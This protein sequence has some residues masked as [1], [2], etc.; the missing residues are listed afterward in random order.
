M[1]SKYVR[2]VLYLILSG[3]LIACGGSGSDD[4]TSE[5]LEDREVSTGIITGFGSV[6]VNGTRYDTSSATIRSDGS[7]LND[8]TELKVGMVATVTSNS[9]NVAS[10]VDYEE[11]VKGPVDVLV[12][13]FGSPFAVMSQTVMVDSAT[14][15]DDSLT[16]P[17][18]A[19]DILEISGIRQS[20]DSI[21]A[22]YIEDKDPAKVNKY[23]VIGNARV[24]DTTAKTFRIDGLTIDYSSADVNDLLGGNPFDG[25]LLEVKDENKTY[26]ASS[27]I[28]TA[29]KVEPFDAFSGN[30]GDSSSIQ[31]LQI[32]SVVTSI[33]IPGE[34]FQV[35]NFTVNILPSTSFLF[36]AVGDIAVGTVL[37]I[38]AVKSANGELDATRIRFKRNSARMEAPVDTGGV[39]LANNQLSVVGVT[40]QINSSTELEDDRD[41]IAPFT[42]NDIND[43]DYLEIRGFTSADGVFIANELERDDSD[44]NVEIRGIASNI[45]PVGQSMEILGITI[46]AGPGTQFND[47]FVSAEAFFGALTEGLSIVKVKWDPFTNTGLAPKEIEIEDDFTMSKL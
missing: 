7:I 6:F 25:Q 13:D 27:G 45:D 18:N 2:I 4:N 47:G 43:N 29:T 37:Q 8:V 46:T 39:D 31:N 30:G 22:T 14:I 33:T 1:F 9:T 15:I 11:D 41:D 40:V 42:I 35:P 36:G 12:S 5:S 26:L 21:L 44:D 3:S 20:D 23:K 34:Q 24:I 32:E 19:G 10:R 28:L 16:L 17:V 38:K